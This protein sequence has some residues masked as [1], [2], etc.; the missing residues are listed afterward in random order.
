MRDTI[1]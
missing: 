1:L